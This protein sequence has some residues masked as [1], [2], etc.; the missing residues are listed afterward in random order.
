MYARNAL[1]LNALNDPVVAKDSAAAAYTT[2]SMYHICTRLSC[3]LNW[4]W[5]ILLRSLVRLQH[6]RPQRLGTE[7]Q[8]TGL[9]ND[10]LVHWE[11]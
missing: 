10:R 3:P 2:Q 9:F 1:L 5:L 8:S 11:W 4:L 7:S 6:S